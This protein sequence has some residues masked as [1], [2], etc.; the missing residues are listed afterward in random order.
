M[1]Y[2][3]SCFSFEIILFYKLI[4]LLVFT[5]SIATVSAFKSQTQCILVMMCYSLVTGGVPALVA[6]SIPA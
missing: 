2:R 5:F 6:L 4:R 1:E 3:I